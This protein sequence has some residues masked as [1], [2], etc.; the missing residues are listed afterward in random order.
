MKE[1]LPMNN[2]G[3]LVN[4]DKEMY[5]D[6]RKVAEFFEKEHYTV[7]RDIDVLCKKL[8]ASSQDVGAYKIVFSSYKVMY[9]DISN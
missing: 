2:Y 9:V 6:S 4:T 3:L 5:V 1:L 8:D 7:L